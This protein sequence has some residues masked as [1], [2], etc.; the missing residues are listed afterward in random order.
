KG[1]R[2]RAFA[3]RTR[4]DGSLVDVELISEPII[5]GEEPLGFLAIYHDITELQHQ[6]RYFEAVLQ[7]SPTAIVTVDEQ[8]HVRSWNPMAEEVFGYTAEEAMGRFIDDLVAN[9]PDL[10]DEAASMNLTGSLGQRARQIGRRT[11]KDGS[12]VDVEIVAGPVYIGEER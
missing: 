3:R 7:L 2:V 1:E 6:R 4:K 10:R 11:R 8:F 9:S 5:V 12:F